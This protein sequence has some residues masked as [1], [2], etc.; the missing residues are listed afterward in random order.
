MYAMRVNVCV[1]AHAG[2]GAGADLSIRA[3]HRKGVGSS[4][5]SNS[6]VATLCLVEPGPRAASVF[7]LPLFP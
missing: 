3:S 7:F 2:A 6:L 5:G 4:V 1:H